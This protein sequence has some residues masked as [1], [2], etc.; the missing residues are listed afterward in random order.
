[1]R[2]VASITWNVM[3]EEAPLLDVEV[4]VGIVS[5]D[6][7]DPLYDNGYSVPRQITPVRARSHTP[8]STHPVLALSH[9]AIANKTLRTEFTRELATQFGTLAR[10]KLIEPGL[11]VS[12]P[13]DSSNPRK[14]Q[15]FNY[16][17][18]SLWRLNTLGQKIVSRCRTQ[19]LQRQNII[20]VSV[21]VHPKFGPNQS[22]NKSLTF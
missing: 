21:V 8:R 7:T 4:G 19:I 5:V 22:R 13:W 9:R 15:I 10:E 3:A 16:L 17:W 12:N 2:S 14:N 1:M 18:R 6:D 11:H 20:S